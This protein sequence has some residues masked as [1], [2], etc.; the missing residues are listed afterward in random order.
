MEG[1][2]D[3]VMASTDGI[4]EG[5]AD[6]SREGGDVNSDNGD[7]DKDGGVVTVEGFAENVE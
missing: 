1:I 4:L 7:V 5:L 2:I 3:V 6:E